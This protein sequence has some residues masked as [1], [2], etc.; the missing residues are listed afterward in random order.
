MR[1]Q[2]FDTV[3][4]SL[5]SPV[6]L[7][8]GEEG[9]G[10]T[11]L[12]EHFIQDYAGDGCGY[13]TISFTWNGNRRI[14]SISKFAQMLLRSGATA[15]DALEE[16]NEFLNLELAEEKKDK[17]AATRETEGHTYTIHG[18]SRAKGIQ[19]AQPGGEEESALANVFIGSIVSWLQSGD[20]GSGSELETLLRLIFVFDAFESYPTPVKSWLGRHLLPALEKNPGIPPMSVILT[21]RQPWE[22]SGQADYWKTD[23]GALKQFALGPLSRQDCE[24]WLRSE[25][26]QL[27][28]L[29]LVYEET[30]GNPG[31]IKQVLSDKNNLEQR[32]RSGGDNSNPLSRFSAQERRWL[33]AASMEEGLTL[34]A[35]QLIL[36]RVEGTQAFGWLSRHIDFCQVEVTPRNEHVLVLSGE[37]RD[38]VLNRMTPKVPA[39]HREF[40]SKISLMRQVCHKVNSLEH[41]GNLR[42]LTPLQPFTRNL[43]KEVFHDEG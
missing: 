21:G 22:A 2:V 7:V 12:V 11:G 32:L 13:D 40:E 5:P 8:H 29:D 30:E 17:E 36:G 26:I 33:H 39:R 35:L 37:M 19:P 1:R 41:R 3:N 6:L 31:R 28:L 43:I 23:V 15:I 10:K 34:E 20:L 9:I 27:S 14:T 24:D 42:V 4:G 38:T 25:G 18:S 16:N